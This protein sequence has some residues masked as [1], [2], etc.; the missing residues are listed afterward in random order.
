MNIFGSIAS[1]LM[2]E[3]V[4][5][6]SVVPVGPVIAKHVGGLEPGPEPIHKLQHAAAG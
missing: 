2:P 1:S 5:I 6:A 4:S 3:V